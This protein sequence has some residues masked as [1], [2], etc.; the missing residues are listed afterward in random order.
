MNAD[1]GTLSP[2]EALERARRA[3]TE[4]RQVAVRWRIAALW[5]LTVFL[6]AHVL[7]TRLFP[8]FLDDWTLVFLGVTMLLL[9]VLAFTARVYDR[10]ATRIEGWFVVGM[11]AVTVLVA[12]LYNPVIP[13]G[14]TVWAYAVSAL[15]VAL[16]VVFT[17]W[18]VRR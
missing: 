14:M 17:V 15:P 13:D 2:A 6:T 4:T 18:M 7:G 16:A 9:A 3:S 8:E 10:R 11:V 1:N 12:V 5:I